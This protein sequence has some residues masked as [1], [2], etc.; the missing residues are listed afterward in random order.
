MPRVGRALSVPQTWKDKEVSWKTI[1]SETGCH[2][3]APYLE[4]AASKAKDGSKNI[5]VGTPI[6]PNG[7]KQSGLFLSSVAFPQI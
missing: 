2:C 5:I 7:N 3:S 1:S 6:Y 4:F